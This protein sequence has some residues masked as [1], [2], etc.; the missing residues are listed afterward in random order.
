MAGEAP[1]RGSVL[2]ERQDYF[3]TKARRH[4]ASGLDVLY[5]SS[6]LL[7]GS[8]AAPHRLAQHRRRGTMTP[9]HPTA[10]ATTEEPPCNSASLDWAGWEPIF[11]AG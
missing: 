7:P 4:E 1:D 9:T 2:A 10:A 11:P 3:T 6:P 8:A 5:P